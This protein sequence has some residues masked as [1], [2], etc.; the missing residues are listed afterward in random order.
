MPTSPPPPPPARLQSLF[1]QPQCHAV[2]ATYRLTAGASESQIPGNTIRSTLVLHI[3][4]LAM[5][6]CSLHVCLARRSGS[7]TADYRTHPIKSRFSVR[8]HTT[9][10]SV[11]TS[12]S[13]QWTSGGSLPNS[14][15]KNGEQHALY[16]S[17]QALRSLD[18][19]K[20][21]WIEQNQHG[22][23]GGDFCN[24]TPPAF[25]GWLLRSI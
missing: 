7:Q 25:F 8:M 1:D 22:P 14:C 6:R 11:H 3:R 2:A 21:S 13:E 18:A 15:Q 12:L 10:S 9:P 24:S 20:D 16:W 4:S 17:L 23:A 5:L 19:A